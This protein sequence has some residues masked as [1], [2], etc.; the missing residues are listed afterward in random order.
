VK[1]WRECPDCWGTGFVRG[2]GANCGK[3]PPTPKPD[4]DD[5]CLGFDARIVGD[6][7]LLRG[8]YDYPYEAPNEDPW[9]RP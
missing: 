5:M 7:E 2:F 1:G 9:N 3:Q 8:M 6:D 4:D